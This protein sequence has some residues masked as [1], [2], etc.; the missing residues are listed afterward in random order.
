MEN[1]P[2]KQKL[3][4]VTSCWPAIAL[5]AV[6][7]PGAVRAQDE[8]LGSYVGT[9][10]ISGTLI[11]PRGSY[12]AKVKVSLPVSQSD[13]D[14]IE[15]EF[16]SGEAPN[17]TAVISDWDVAYTEKSADSDGKYSSW[18]CSLPGAAEI[19]MSV[20][21]VLNVDLAAGTYALAVTLLSTEQLEFDCKNSRSGPY[22]KKEGISLH[23][24][25]GVPG[26]QS[27]QPLPFTDAAHLRA[28]YTLHSKDAEMNN[29]GP[30]IQEWDLR[31][32]P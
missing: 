30:V 8:G 27:G 7:Y 16:L 19:P 28:S 3:F 11:D 15:A 5:A 22:K 9:L 26:M 14:S 13:D 25:T 21:G 31:R 29:Y 32:T 1:P 18:R 24:G 23:A 17:A 2:G 20:T 10:N 4:I 6:A 12:R